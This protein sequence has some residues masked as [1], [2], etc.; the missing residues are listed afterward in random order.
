MYVLLKNSTSSIWPYK[1]I[2]EKSSAEIR[3]ARI[4]RSKQDFCILSE[5]RFFLGSSMA[6]CSG[7]IKLDALSYSL[8][9]NLWVKSN[10][11]VKI[12]KK[13]I[14]KRLLGHPVISVCTTCDN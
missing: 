7:K 9:K 13:L 11:I 8:K 1:N 2:K 14:P 10:L 5:M 12:F 4:P 3:V 6:S